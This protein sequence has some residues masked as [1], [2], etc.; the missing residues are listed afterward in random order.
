MHPIRTVVEGLINS[1]IAFQQNVSVEKKSKIA[2]VILVLF[3]VPLGVMVIS[4]GIS[5]D[6]NR[7]AYILFGI[8]LSIFPFLL[9]IFLKR[10]RENLITL[11]SREGIQVQKG[12]MYTWETLH[13]INFNISK[14]KYGSEKQCY[15]I[16]FQFKEGYARATYTTDKFSY[17]L[18]IADQLPVKKNRKENAEHM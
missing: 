15:L 11:V 10:I 9:Q 2:F 3:F 5:S 12:K 14:A 6:T 13:A 8:L 17:I 1:P 18:F 7:V 4:G 16:D